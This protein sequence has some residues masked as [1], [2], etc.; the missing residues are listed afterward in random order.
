MRDL[1]QFFPVD[2]ENMVEG[3]R[4]RLAMQRTRLGGY[5]SKKLAQLD[6]AKNTQPEQRPPPVL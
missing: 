2:Y 5:H 4:Q 6:D 1:S 3:N